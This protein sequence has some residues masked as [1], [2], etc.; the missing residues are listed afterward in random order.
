MPRFPC[1]YLRF[2]HLRP[3][4]FSHTSPHTHPAAPP[5][6]P[7]PRDRDSVAVALE[8]HEKQRVRG[9]H[10]VHL[11]YVG[12]LHQLHTKRTRARRSLSPAPPHATDA[13]PH[14]QPHLL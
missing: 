2:A 4:P 7:V 8:R 5:R 1:R 3:A 13:A 9:G 6:A 12:S 11:H 10:V 14:G